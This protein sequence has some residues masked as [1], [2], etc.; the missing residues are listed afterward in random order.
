MCPTVAEKIKSVWLFSSIYAKIRF[1][2]AE[3]YI[4]VA[5]QSIV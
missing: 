3:K 1:L 5:I 4:E 2:N